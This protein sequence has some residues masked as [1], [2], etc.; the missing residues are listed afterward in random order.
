M[1]KHHSTCDLGQGQLCSAD[2]MDRHHAL[3]Y[4]R[5]CSGPG[6]CH[7]VIHQMV[8]FDGTGNNRMAD[9]NDSLPVHKPSN[10]AKLSRLAEEFYRAWKN[11]SSQLSDPAIHDPASYELVCQDNI[12]K[13]NGLL[14]VAQPIYIAGVG[15]PYNE[16]QNILE[17]FRDSP[18]LGG[19]LARG[20]EIRLKGAKARLHKNISDIVEGIAQTSKRGKVVLHVVG[21]SRGATLARTF[22]NALLEK[23]P[24]RNPS[25]GRPLMHDITTD[26]KLAPELHIQSLGLFDTVSSVGF[27]GKTWGGVMLDIPAQVNNCLHFVAAH[28]C[29]DFFPLSSIAGNRA[30]NSSELIYPGVHSDIGGGYKPNEQGKTNELTKVTL[31]E[32]LHFL[33]DNGAPIFSFDELT[34]FKQATGNRLDKLY[35]D[36]DYP[37]AIWNGVQAYR[38]AS[39]ECS[40]VGDISDLKTRIIQHMEIYHRWRGMRDRSFLPEKARFAELPDVQTDIN[41]IDNYDWWLGQM[42]THDFLEGDI[43]VLS[44]NG[45]NKTTRPML[46]VEKRWL[47]AWCEGQRTG[48]TQP[49]TSL[50]IISKSLFDNHIHDS[51]AGFGMRGAEQYMK[52]RGIVPDDGS[53]GNPDA[54][55]QDFRCKYGPKKKKE[56]EIAQVAYAGQPDSGTRLV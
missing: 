34:R 20:F 6:G 5:T 9:E 28:E 48:N 55:L 26:L 27:P 25:S 7:W 13:E 47:K 15:T 33:W 52:L 2:N 16:D 46:P 11:H 8:F 29:R 32:M 1:P 37:D 24:H 51:V 23:Y 36:F 50:G 53:P 56:E 39:G 21:F 30:Q 12:G 19:A 38:T 18:A 41:A 14:Q 22:V 42:M 43:R 44:S 40:D 17:N 35:R 54:P 31:V 4:Y 45:G 49:E 10:V 3:H